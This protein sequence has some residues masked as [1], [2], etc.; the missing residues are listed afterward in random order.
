MLLHA[1]CTNRWPS[2]QQR[3]AAE[4]VLRKTVEHGTS[5][6]NSGASA[7]DI[8]VEVVRL[9]EDCELFNAGIGAALTAEGDHEVSLHCLRRMSTPLTFLL[10]SWKPV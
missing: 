2:K 4:L 7:V 1:G 10:S 6:L 9:L 3:Q 8:A 5:F